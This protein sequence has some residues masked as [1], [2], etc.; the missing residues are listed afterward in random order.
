MGYFRRKIDRRRAR[1]AVEMHAAA[2]VADAVW[3]ALDEVSRE[4]QRDFIRFSGKAAGDSS[5][6]R[7]GVFTIAYDVCRE[8]D[9]GQARPLR[10]ELSWFERHLPVPRRIDERSIFWFR[11]DAGEVATRV[12]QLVDLL[13]AHG[14]LIEVQRVRLFPGRV[15]YED[16]YQIAAIP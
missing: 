3:R 5:V 8:L 6:R 11:S 1:V 14:W 13:V 12:W 4:P 9:A 16:D 10:D 2:P 15:V 7:L